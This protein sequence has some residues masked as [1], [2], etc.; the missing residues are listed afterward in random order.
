[1]LLLP[2]DASDVGPTPRVPIRDVV[3][4]FWPYARSFRAYLALSFVLVV[5][6]PAIEAAQIWMF[7][8]AVDDVLVPRDLGPLPVIAAAYL[9]LAVLGGIVSFGNDYL[10]TCLGESFVLRLRT[11]VFRHLQGLSLDFFERRPVGDLVS[12]LT[13]DVAAIETFV[14]SG[15]TR[16]LSYGMRIA[17]FAAA[18]FYLRWELALIAL[19]VAPVAW[20][21]TRYF[22]RR[23]K[24]ASR[25]KRRRTGSLSSVVEESL[26]G[27]QLVQA[28]NRQEYEVERFHR[29][30]R[31]TAAAELAATRMKAVFAPLL[32]LLMVV[33]ALLVI[34]VGTIELDQGRLTL[35]GL[36]VFLTYLARLYSPIQGLGRLGN[37]VFA[38][39][40]GAERV[41]ELLDERPTVVERPHAQRIDWARGEVAFESVSF[42]YRGA[43]KDAIEDVSF[44]LEPGETLALVGRSGAGKSTI[45]KL[46]LRFYDPSDGAVRLDGIDLRELELAS[47]REN[48]A[49]LLQEA[50]V[51]DGT[52][53]DNI[54]Y[55]RPGARDR[56]IVR[57]AERADAHEFVSAL[58]DGYDTWI[59]QRGRRLSGGERQRIAIARAMI[60]DAP[61]LLLDEPTTGLDVFTSRRILEPLRRLMS[62]RATIVITHNFLTVKDAT[63]ILVLDRGRVV[64]A[65]EHAALLVRDGLYAELYR[66]HQATPGLPPLAVAK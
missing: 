55:G 11:S 33:G 14:V 19:V 25:E 35:G 21:A 60:R 10:S 9:S 46:L 40:T 18:L 34:A 66:L 24:E 1:M 20:T 51:F 52:I 61:V 57:A 22:S 62:G 37:S 63:S 58:P 53:R 65:G 45:A 56:D 47:L 7:K 23:I 2:E 15:V 4:R 26:G 28:Y 48:V 32:E 3:R 42:R 27:I 8:L 12:R 13:G 44:R 64:E 5:L 30:S 49:L 36:L 54:A 43:E 38:A 16:A 6:V 31:G 59:G 41:I 17:I 39:S 29:E 50:L